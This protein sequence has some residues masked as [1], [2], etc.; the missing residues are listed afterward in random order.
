MRLRN[1][2]V[3]HEARGVKL[4]IG[5]AVPH[6]ILILKG[7]QHS[8]SISNYLNTLQ[9]LIINYLEVVLHY[10]F[11]VRPLQQGG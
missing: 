6:P 9:Q 8:A 3:L 10:P 4:P 1:R 5:V 7:M 11:C 2:I